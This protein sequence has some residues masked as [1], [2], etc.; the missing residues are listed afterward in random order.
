MLIQALKRKGANANECICGSLTS[1]IW[2]PN[3]QWAVSQGR[4]IMS[5]T[6]IPKAEACVT[7]LMQGTVTPTECEWE[8]DSNT[9]SRKDIFHV[10]RREEGVR[11]VGGEVSACHP[12]LIWLFVHTNHWI[13]ASKWEKLVFSVTNWP[14][15]TRALTERGNGEGKHGGWG[16]SSSFGEQIPN[17]VDCDKTIL[18][19]LAFLSVLKS[20]KI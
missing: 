18:Y 8:T 20:H 1:P 14:R 5:R 10:C 11:E 3:L 6:G 13:A 12:C 4:R 17:I 15:A 9:E 19:F 16:R 2:C 7:H